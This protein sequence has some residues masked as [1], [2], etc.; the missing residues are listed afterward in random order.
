MKRSYWLWVVVV[1]S[2]A[3]DVGV[4]V[5]PLP[6]LTSSAAF[7]EVWLWHAISCAILASCSFFLLPPRY[8]QTPVWTWLLMFDFA[9]VAPVA[10]PVGL[11]LVARSTLHHKDDQAVYAKP[12]VLDLPEYDIRAQDP[13]RAGQ[14]AIRS[15]LGLNVPAGVRM[16]S[17]LSLQAVPSRVAN[18]IREELL[19]DVADD[20]RLVAFGMLEAEEKR[21]T[22]HIHHEQKNL[23]LELSARARF[24]CLI[25]LAELHW[26]LVY[27]ALV[28]GELR[29]HILS[30]AR[31]YI[32]AA[33]ALG[34][35]HQSG[36]MFLKGKILL[37]QGEG[38]Q[39]EVA[40]REA[41]DLGHSEM[42]VVPFLAELAFRRREFGRV[43][44]DMQYLFKHYAASR[45]MP[46]VDFWAAH[47]SVHQIRD[48]RT[49]RH[50]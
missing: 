13:Q 43:R 17:L 39:A 34:E 33:L 28:Q 30:E 29:K 27:S 14:G 45:V 26:E 6:R 15:R 10:G 3:L 21:L 20:V 5:G 38:A 37:A 24:D 35:A 40:L 31:E 46:I 32:D 16:Q 7:A 42:S 11:L 4:F 22:V 49:S 2:I 36:I 8:R 41:L 47:D 44:D 25:H 23:E 19:G 9:F 1:L 18:P 48:Q 12:L 50:I